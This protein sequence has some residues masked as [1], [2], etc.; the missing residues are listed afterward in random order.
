MLSEPHPPF[1]LN[2]VSGALGL[3]VP[4][5]LQTHRCPWPSP[6]GHPASGPKPVNGVFVVPP[7][8]PLEAAWYGLPPSRVPSVGGSDSGAGLG[9]LC[10]P[11]P[12]ATPPAPS[13][14]SQGGQDQLSPHHPVCRDDSADLGSGPSRYQS[15]N[16]GLDW[17][18]QRGSVSA[19]SRDTQFSGAQAMALVRFF[20]LILIEGYL[21]YDRVLVSALHHDLVGCDK[22]FVIP[23]SWS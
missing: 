19:F 7:L 10:L 17:A 22:R 11:R 12:R 1:S 18:G 14:Q 21:L 15:A 23:D 3:E 2:K 4:S 6:R 13:G 5:A 9:Q 20:F 8:W 16:G